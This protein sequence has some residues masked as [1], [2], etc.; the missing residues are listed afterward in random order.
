MTDDT[1]DSAAGVRTAVV[2][3][4]SRGLGRGIAE[5]LADRGFHVVV[6]LTA[7]SESPQSCSSKFPRSRG[8]ASAGL[9]RW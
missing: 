7:L 9:C 5:A 2:T 6:T 4:G 3:G 8:N 1:R